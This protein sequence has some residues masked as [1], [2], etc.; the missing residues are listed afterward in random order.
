MLDRYG[1]FSDNLFYTLDLS[2]A[3]ISRNIPYFSTS[4]M[5]VDCILSHISHISYA[6]IDH[7]NVTGFFYKTFD[8]L[9]IVYEFVLFFLYLIS[10]VIVLFLKE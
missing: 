5:T 6:C 8:P 9:R 10:K 2:M 1:R 3:I 7:K 4:Y